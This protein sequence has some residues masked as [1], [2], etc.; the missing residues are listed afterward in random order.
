MHQ[1]FNI[2]WQMKSCCFMLL[3]LHLPLYICGSKVLGMER[4]V[5]ILRITSILMILCSGN[6]IGW[7]IPSMPKSHFISHQLRHLATV[8]HIPLAMATKPSTIPSLNLY[9]A[10]N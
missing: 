3:M 7:R 6:F 10:F 2:C 1:V 4:L 8:T 5:L 9:E